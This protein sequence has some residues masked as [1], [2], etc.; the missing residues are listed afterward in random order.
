MKTVADRNRR[1]PLQLSR[2]KVLSCD[3]NAMFSH[4]GNRS[5]ILRSPLSSSVK[6]GRS[7]Q[8]V[9]DY[10]P[11]DSPSTSHSFNFSND[12][13]VPTNNERDHFFTPV[14]DVS[15]TSE[16]NTTSLTTDT[17]DLEKEAASALQEI[18]AGLDLSHYVA[19]KADHDVSRIMISKFTVYSDCIQL[20]LLNLNRGCIANYNSLAGIPIL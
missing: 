18:S 5:P 19:G 7:L 10:E 17:Q 1:R 8:D 15:I 6:T 16:M 20:S 11:T 2:R 3:M 4:P 13:P 12:T 14:R 9:N